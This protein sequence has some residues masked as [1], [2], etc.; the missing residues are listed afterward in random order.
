MS[1][2]PGKPFETAVVDERWEAT[3]EV[4]GASHKRIAN[5]R[6]YFDSPPVLKNNELAEIHVSADTLDKLKDRMKSYIDL[7]EE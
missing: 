5:E 4:K 2:T 7:L 3:I 6:G 1:T